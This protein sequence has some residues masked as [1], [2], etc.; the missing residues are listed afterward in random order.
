[1]ASNVSGNAILRAASDGE[2]SP[3]EAGDLHLLGDAGHSL[4]QLVSIILQYDNLIDDVAL[5]VERQANVF[6]LISLAEALS[7]HLT[8]QS[9]IKTTFLLYVRSSG[10]ISAG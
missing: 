9:L 10:A 8:H 2:I 6:D 7:P 4:L 1:L 3:D 5:N